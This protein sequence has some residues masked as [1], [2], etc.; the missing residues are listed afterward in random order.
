MG[1]MAALPIV[2]LPVGRLCGDRLEVRQCAPRMGAP[3]TGLQ[4]QLMVIVQAILLVPLLGL[5]WLVRPLE[6]QPP[7]H[8]I[9]HRRTTI[10][11]RI[12]QRWLGFQPV[13]SIKADVL[14]INESWFR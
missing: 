6:R 3:P 11:H 14:A 10:R 12:S 5:R 9:H 7:H 8:T 1:R 13:A 4:H 2:D